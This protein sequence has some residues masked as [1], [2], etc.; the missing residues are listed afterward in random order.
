M[1]F[2]P[3]GLFIIS[4]C[5]IKLFGMVLTLDIIIRKWTHKMLVI[6]LSFPLAL[7]LD[8]EQTEPLCWMNLT[9]PCTLDQYSL[10]CAR[11]SALRLIT[12]SVL[13]RFLSGYFLLEVCFRQVIWSI[14]VTRV[15]HSKK[16]ALFH[17]S[18]NATIMVYN[19]LF[20][21]FIKFQSHA[22]SNS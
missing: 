17:C 16:N 2:T 22:K 1:G 18:S 8:V 21:I 4:K 15:V 7:T 3:V 14:S 13:L 20:D 19:N 10:P 6:Y 11:T 12:L 5:D 9:G